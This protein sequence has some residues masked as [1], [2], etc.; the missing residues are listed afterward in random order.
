MLLF[1]CVVLQFRAAAL[2]WSTI[3]GCSCWL[4]TT[5]GVPAWLSE[6]EGLSGAVHCR[7]SVA[8]WLQ[9]CSQ[10]P[11]LTQHLFSL[12]SHS[13]VAEMDQLSLRGMTSLLPAL[14]IPCLP[15]FLPPLT[16]TWPRWTSSACA[17]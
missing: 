6:G 17:A 11:Q 1:F 9:C 13:Y 3:P 5:C 14:N 2:W 10:V 12:I 7:M 15:V 4:A 8:G 16:A